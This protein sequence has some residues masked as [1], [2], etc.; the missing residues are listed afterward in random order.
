MGEEI[1]KKSFY[2]FSIKC[3]LSKMSGSLIFRRKTLGKAGIIV[4]TGFSNC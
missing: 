1:E 2:S 4:L 3:M